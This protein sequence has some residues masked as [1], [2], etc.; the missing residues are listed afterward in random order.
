MLEFG[1]SRRVVG[2]KQTKKALKEGRASV[3][4]IAEDAQTAV[5]APIEELC[6]EQGVEVIKAPSMAQLGA[7]CNIEVGAATVAILK[8]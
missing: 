6:R 3:V 8:Q 4:Y 1:D 5:V 7:A 2:L